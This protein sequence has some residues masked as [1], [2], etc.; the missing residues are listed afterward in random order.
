M[1]CACKFSPCINWA[2]L[3]R[4]PEQLRLYPRAP[5]ARPF[6]GRLCLLVFLPGAASVPPR[7][8]IFLGKKSA[9]GTDCLRYRSHLGQWIW[10]GLF[11]F[12]PHDSPGLLQAT[13]LVM[14]RLL[15]TFNFFSC[16]ETPT[17]R[18]SPCLDICACVFFSEVSRRPFAVSSTD[19]IPFS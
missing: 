13:T 9:F 19:P 5:D 8:T 17:Y 10:L 11:L 1:A 14:A 6:S 2:G 3:S 16:F 12:A 15:S 18:S 4:P 7:Y